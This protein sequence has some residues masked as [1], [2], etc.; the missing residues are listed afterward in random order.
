MINLKKNINIRN[1]YK[2]FFFDLDGVLI[3]SLK[4]MEYAWNKTA[5]KHKL[6][7]GFSQ[8]KKHMGLPFYKILENLGIDPKKFSKIKKTYEKESISNLGRIKLY[9]GV[10]Q[11]INSIKNKD[12]KVAVVTSKNSARTRKIIK[13]KNLKLDFVS[14]PNNRLKG[15]PYP[16]QLL[17]AI[18]KLGIKNKD[19][20]VFVGDTIND[21]LTSL[22]S[23]VDF[24]YVKYGYGSISS[25]KIKKIKVYSISKIMDL[26][27][28]IS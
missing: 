16:D 27:Y 4:N 13:L 9:K 10:I 22:N 11:I 3:N 7:P 8:Y 20:C 12:G 25:E 2:F 14:T 17:Y 28:L 19:S 6:K 5:I 24:V 1:K 23:N 26:K 18:K 15:K 21:F